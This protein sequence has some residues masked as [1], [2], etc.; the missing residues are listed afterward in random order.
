MKV[1]EQEF[2]EMMRGRRKRIEALES[3][4]DQV[5][6]KSIR[7]VGVIHRGYLSRIEIILPLKTVS[8]ANASEHWAKSHKRKH[9]QAEEV[10]RE[11]Y[12]L[13]QMVRVELP[14]VVKFTRIAP[15]KLD[16]GDNLAMCFKKIRD[17]VAKI[18]EIDDGGDQVKWEYDQQ[19]VR[20]R[21]YAVKI[22]IYK[23]EQ[24]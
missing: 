7:R 19:P 23:P 14:C 9:S 22:E 11:W 1:T 17:A 2:A 21:S 5:K 12:R 16:E 13:L 6:A 8:E 4:L 3:T 18:L 10:T 20:R 15:K 24:R